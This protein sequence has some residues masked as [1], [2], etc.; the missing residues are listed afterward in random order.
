MEPAALVNLGGNVVRGRRGSGGRSSVGRTSLKFVDTPEKGMRDDT[1]IEVTVA[2]DQADKE[3]AEDAA[4]SPATPAYLAAPETLVQQT[5]PINRMRK[6]GSK[7]KDA[8]KLRRLTFFN[9]A[10]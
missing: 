3:N 1:T 10:A 8:A 7:T 4:S 5:A 2:V 9:G 6:L